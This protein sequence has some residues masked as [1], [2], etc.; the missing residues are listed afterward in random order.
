[1]SQWHP[2]GGVV[3][4]PPSFLMTRPSS[5]S[6]DIYTAVPEAS[7]VCQNR[8]HFSSL[9]VWFC[10]Y[11]LHHH[12]V[13]HEWRNCGVVSDSF[14]SFLHSPVNPQILLPLPPTFVPRPASILCPLFQARIICLGLPDE[15]S[16]LSPLQSY[17]T[18][19]PI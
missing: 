13:S 4:V 10:S 18:G 16:W 17:L 8:T 11:I 12:P 5:L 15:Y 3:P 7:P 14:F 6:L 9:Q 1:M 19:I 2:M